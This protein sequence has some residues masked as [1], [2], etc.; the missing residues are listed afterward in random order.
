MYNLKKKYAMHCSYDVSM[1]IKHTHVCVVWC[2]SLFYCGGNQYNRTHMVNW[3]NAQ[4]QNKFTKLLYLISQTHN[5]FYWLL[6]TKYQPLLCWWYAC[7]LR[8]IVIFLCIIILHACKCACLYMDMRVCMP[9]YFIGVLVFTVCIGKRVFSCGRV[10]VK[11]C[12]PC[13]YFEVFTS[14]HRDN[15]EYRYVLLK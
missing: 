2:Q 1:Y 7:V 12:G 9:R 6:A 8:Y 5:G 11:M 15:G 13:L 14:T 3:L 10:C 4:V